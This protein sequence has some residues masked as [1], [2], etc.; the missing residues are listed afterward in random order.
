MIDT[1]RSTIIEIANKYC[2]L[3]G[4][5]RY[6]LFQKGKHKRSIKKRLVNGV[7]VCNIRMALGYYLVNH[8][9]ITLNEAASLI[10]YNDHS[11]ICFNNKKIYF[12]IKNN[13]EK[14]MSFYS[15]LLEVGKQYPTFKLKRINKN[16]IILN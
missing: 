8:F 2:E 3:Y 1:M 6:D 12:Y 13:D 5:T 16:Q 14:F 7:S 11:T 15:V 9:P 4:I 10:G